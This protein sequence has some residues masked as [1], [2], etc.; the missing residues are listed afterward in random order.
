MDYFKR[1]LPMRLLREP[2]PA[3]GESAYPRRYDPERNAHNGSIESFSAKLEIARQPALLHVT[4]QTVFDRTA[5]AGN[6]LENGRTIGREIDSSQ[7]GLSD[8]PAG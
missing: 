6:R 2:L 7:S 4:L 3:E 5:A 8:C 1:E